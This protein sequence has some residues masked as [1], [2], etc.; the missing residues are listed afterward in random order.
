M[1][2]RDL[3]SRAG[4]ALFAGLLCCAL[5]PAVRAA[6]APA[7]I[8]SVGGAVTEILYDL[9]LSDRI[10]GLD[11]TSLFP[12]EALKQKP[13]VGYMR[14]LSVEG[15]LSLKPDLVLAV[16]GAGP[17]DAL[18]ALGRTGIRIAR[19]PEALTPQAVEDRIRLVGGLAGAEPRAQ[20]LAAQVSARF[21]ALDTL[22]PAGGKPVR[23]LFVLSLQNGR[24]LAGGR[25]T[26]A[27]SMIT[28]AGGMNAAAVEGYKPMGDEAIIAAA[29]D[30]VLMMQ[31]GAAP[32]SAATLFAMPAFAA[33][34]AA[35]R[36][37]L[38]TMD[39]LA[40]LGFGPRTPEVLRDLMLAFHPGLTLPP[41]PAAP[42]AGR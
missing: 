15:V 14:A 40:L 31:T 6:E 39:G 17:P 41:L 32:V 8:V 37:A 35:R 2:P 5:S 36:Q 26:A 11:T 34:P 16:E 42:G 13:N 1:T 12:P 25:G 20:A 28:L 23:V 22:R 29:P 24:V 33:T 19:V 27:D 3:I 4:R 10:V 38:V 30:V 21:V 9:G 18:E 7:R